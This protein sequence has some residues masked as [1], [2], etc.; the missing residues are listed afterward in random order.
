M[1]TVFTRALLLIVFVNPHVSISQGLRITAGAS[2]VV[3]GSA[4]IVIHD[5]GLDNAGTFLPGSGTVVLM[6]TASTVITGP[7]N[8]NNLTINKSAGGTSLGSN[9]AVASLVTMTAGGLD[10]NGFELDLGSTGALANEAVGHLITGPTGG[11]IVRTVTLNAPSAVA[12]GNMGI[13]ITSAANLG[14]TV[15]RRGHLQP[16]SSAGHG[17]NR[18]FEI[19]PTNNTALNATLRFHYED[20]ELAGINE[21]ELIFWSSPTGAQPWNPLGADSRDLALNFVEK[22]NINVM[23]TFALASSVNNTLPVELLYFEGELVND[24]VQLQWATASEMNSAHFDVERSEDGSRFVSIAK[25]PAK[26][27]SAVTNRYNYTDAMASSTSYYRLKQ[28]DID[29]KFN[30]SKVIAISQKP[31]DALLNVFPN[32]G[33][34]RFNIRFM[35]SAATTVKLSVMDNM[36]N[37]VVSKP[38]QAVKG[39][40]EFKCDLDMLPAGN[41]F[42]RLSG[43]DSKVWSLIKR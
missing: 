27:N 18:F 13:T 8:F 39:L 41:Y 43:I 7:V 15:I 19:T 9:I 12:P 38:I 17:I 35:S 28:V 3:S 32:P 14:V 25:L 11:H 34:G 26:G 30:L 36:G 20:T 4:N 40:N 29:G 21:S 1:R 6:G 42:L 2:V 23:Q 16:T 24:K 5:G 37:L 10:L 31:V 33:N 22:T